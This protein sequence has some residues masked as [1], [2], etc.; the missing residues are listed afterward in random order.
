MFQGLR[1]RNINKPFQACNASKKLN[2]YI[3]DIAKGGQFLQLGQAGRQSKELHF[4][5]SKRGGMKWY[6]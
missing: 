5:S 4:M 3:G 2:A 6:F 1:E